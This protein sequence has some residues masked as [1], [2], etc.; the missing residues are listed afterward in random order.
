MRRPAPR[1]GREGRPRDDRGDPAHLRGDRRPQW[2]APGPGPRAIWRDAAPLV[3]ASVAEMQAGRLEPVAIAEFAR[4][5]MLWNELTSLVVTDGYR[6]AERDILARDRRP[7]AAR[8]RSCSGSSPRRRRHRPTAPGRGTS[9][10]RSRSRVPP[11][12]DRAAP[13]GRSHPRA[14][15]DRRRGARRARGPHRPPAGIDG[16]GRRGRRGRHPPA[17][18]RCRCTGGSRSSRAP[19]GPGRTRPGGAGRRPRR[20]RGVRDQAGRRGKEAAVAQP[21]AWVAVGSEA[22]EGVVRCRDLRRPRGRH[23]HGAAA[24]RAGLDPR[25]GAPGRR[26]AAARGPRAGRRR[27]PPGARPAPRRRA[28]GERAHRDAPGVLRRGREHR[29]KPHAGSTWRPG[30]SPTGWSRSSP[31]SAM[32]PTARQAGACRRRC[33]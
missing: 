8:S 1:S 32:R 29:P 26:A 18:R 12:R 24:R 23:A 7:G 28:H 11:G 5:I 13:G 20:A 6:A 10:P 31:C 16:P 27:R 33:S 4:F 22:V 25:P 17:R 19:T 3:G 9:R 2:P 15:G 30:R 21:Q 14:A